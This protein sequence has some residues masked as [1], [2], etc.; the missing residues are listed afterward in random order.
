MGLW[1]F[2]TRNDR[3]M[4]VPAARMATAALK[5]IQASGRDPR[6]LRYLYRTLEIEPNNAQALIILSEL[7]RGATHGAKPTGDAIFSGI[8]L[9]YAMDPK[10]LLAPTHKPAFDKART[11]IMTAWGFGKTRGTEVDL[12]HIAYMQYIHELMGTV[13]SV[14]RGFLMA[15]TK[16]G[17]QA[18]C[19]DGA[20]GKTTRS[21]DEWL[22]SPNNTLPA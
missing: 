12:D 10:T 5:S 1:P 11:A 6:A 19:V 14:S 8:V 13:G 20:T 22:R 18:G 21:Y 16:I 7:F 4:D 2:G 3:M 15:L 9:E 17:V